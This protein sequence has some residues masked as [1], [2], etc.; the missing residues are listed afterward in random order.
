MITYIAV[1][2][3]SGVL[4]AILD[5]LLN[6]NPLARKLYRVY[7]AIARKRVNIPIG[8]AIDIVY[9]FAMSALYRTLHASLPGGA[10]IVKGLCFAGI[11]WFFRVVMGVASEWM[12]RRVPPAALAY[13]LIAGLAEMLALGILYALT[14][15][16]WS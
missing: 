11:A 8:F 12:T 16:P 10:A 13:T 9:G 6:A 2:L 4:F 14:L 3:G 5:G 15:G 1:G 7:D